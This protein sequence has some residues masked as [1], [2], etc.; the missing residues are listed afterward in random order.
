MQGWVSI[1]KAIIVKDFKFLV[2][3]RSKDGRLDLPGGNLKKG[4]GVCQALLREISEETGLVV[5]TPVS[6]N[7]W[8]IPT[9][10]GMSNGMTFCCD[11]KQG[12]VVL[13]QEHTEYFWQ[14]LEV[15]DNF[16]PRAWTMGSGYQKGGTMLFDRVY[17]QD[18]FEAELSDLEKTVIEF[19]CPLLAPKPADAFPE[20]YIIKDYPENYLEMQKP[21]ESD[22][23]FPHV[24]REVK[25][26]L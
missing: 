11:Y 8:I 15:I 21:P 10:K 19:K 18:Q 22:I 6:I 25:M 4:E 16:T 26:R 13:S 20:H 12:R 9:G 14:S 3:V 7:Q 2:L 17:P 5:E 24:Y 23:M 1:V